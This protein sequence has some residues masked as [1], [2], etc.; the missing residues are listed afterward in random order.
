M[1]FFAVAMSQHTP[2][3]GIALYSS[4]EVKAWQQAEEKARKKMD[5]T[6]R[7]GEV[8]ARICA[9]YLNETP[10]FPKAGETA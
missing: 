8:L 3:K 5:G 6:A 4:E 7:E 10:V 9:E 2:E 1:L